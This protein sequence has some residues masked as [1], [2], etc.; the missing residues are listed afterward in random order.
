MRLYK[1]LCPSFGPFYKIQRNSS[2]FNK[3]QQNSRLFATIGR[4]TTLFPDTFRWQ[5]LFPHVIL[6]IQV[7]KECKT[8]FFFIIHIFSSL[9]FNSPLDSFACALLKK[10]VM[11]DLTFSPF[12]ELVRRHF[13]DR[14]LPKW[15]QPINKYTHAYICPPPLW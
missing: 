7:V 4:A 13:Q 15:G 11:S 12:F 14:V 1:R 2:K 9:I 3:I 6:V 10:K 5:G 8:S